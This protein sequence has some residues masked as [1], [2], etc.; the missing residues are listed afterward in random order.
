M[1]PHLIFCAVFNFSKKKSG[2]PSPR[3]C[4][5]SGSGKLGRWCSC[6]GF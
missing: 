4:R 1:I 6:T 5:T 3:H 2:C